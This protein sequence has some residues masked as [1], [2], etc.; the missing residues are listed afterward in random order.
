M[1]EVERMVYSEDEGYP[2]VYP[3]A[4]AAR[5]ARVEQE[6]RN[7]RERLTKVSPPPRE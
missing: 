5:Q 1:S 4:A 3:D 2:Q 6:S 7:A